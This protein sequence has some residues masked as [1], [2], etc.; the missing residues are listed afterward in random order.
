MVIRRRKYFI[1]F[2]VIL[3]I[4]LVM[5]VAW[6]LTPIKL[7]NIAI[8]DKTVL[9]QQVREHVSFNWVLKNM[10][11]TKKDRNFYQPV[12]DYFGLFPERIDLFDPKKNTYKKKGLEQFS[13]SQIDSIANVLDMAYFTDT[14][15]LY[16]NE[17]RNVFILEHSPLIYGGMS[18]ADIHL[19]TALKAKKK[20]TIT[21]F[22]DIATPTT[23]EIRQKFALLFEVQW[24]GWAGR[25]FDILDT[26]INRELP[27]W[28]KKGYV[29]QHDHRWPF[30]KAGIA[31]VHED[32]RIEILENDTHLNYEYPVI[33]SSDTTIKRFGVTKKMDYAYWFDITRSSPEN[34]ILS[35]YEINTNADGDSV[36]I[37]SGIP[38]RFPAAIERKTDCNFYYFCGD[39]ADNPVSEWLAHLK[40]IDYVKYYLTISRGGSDEGPFFWKYYVP[41][42]RTIMK[43]NFK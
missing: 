27:M 35:W 13:S 2:T 16:S 10:R 29:A 38:K 14:Y 18:A 40:Y 31:F 4:P 1:I 24:T 32:G 15:G 20:L 36:L 34:K 33:V 9:T 5:W 21:E 37:K 23:K 11:I 30:K 25:Y 22:N 28:L 3:L 12:S 42:L 39:F 8:I 26:N 6:L 17:W 7:L 19:L 41:M 43:E